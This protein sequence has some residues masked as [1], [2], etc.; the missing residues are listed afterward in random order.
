MRSLKVVSSLEQ[1]K[2]NFSSVAFMGMVLIVFFVWLLSIIGIISLSWFYTYE[3]ILAWSKI[4]TSDFIR[5]NEENFAVFT[6]RSYVLSHWLSIFLWVLYI[7]LLG[8]AYKYNKT[9]YKLL[10]SL[11]KDIT[12]LL[13]KFIDTFRS[14]SKKERWRYFLLTITIIGFQLKNYFYFPFFGDDL[15]SYVYFSQNGLL[16]TSIF[17]PIPNNHIFYNLLT[18]LFSNFIIDPLLSTRLISFFSFHLLILILFVYLYRTY[19]NK[20][21]AFLAIAFCGFFFTSSI[22]SIQGR[23]YMAFSLFTLISGISLSLYVENKNPT[24]LIL[25]VFSSVLGAYTIPTFLIPFIGITIAF[26]IFSLQ[27]RDTGMLKS[28]FLYILFVGLGVFY[29]YLPTFLFSG[30]NAIVSNKFVTTDARDNFYN[31]VYPIASAEVMSLLAGT[32]KKG[33][34][35]FLILGCLSIPLLKKHQKVRNWILLSMCI[36]GAIF[37]YNLVSRSFMPLR[38]VTYASVYIYVTYAIILTYWIAY[39][40][41]KQTLYVG[42]LSLIPFLGWWQYN[43]TV[44]L[45]YLFPKKLHEVNEKYLNKV[46]VDGKLAYISNELKYLH[47]YYIYK[48]Q[49][50]NQGQALAS[51]PSSAD[52]IFLPSED[53]QLRNKGY[54]LAEEVEEI[55]YSPNY[56]IYEKIP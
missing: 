21:T 49:L 22:Y 15:A 54:R 5:L 56:F 45:N 42:A 17:Y 13:F 4:K 51:Q 43:H 9:L 34:L 44:Y 20:W 48:S 23:G 47:W 30:I 28:V 52:L 27:K 11:S 39:F 6:Y 12:N 33:W 40:R 16:I 32:N 36:V 35:I 41:F 19:R 37:L 50:T 2:K 55:D 26:L 46:F 25:M 3:E 29:T 38:V 1:Y 24:L 7:A 10:K 31:Y 14:L 8:I 53:S 18:S